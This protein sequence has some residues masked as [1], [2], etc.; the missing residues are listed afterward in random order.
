MAS[1][2]TSLS[3]AS[4]KPYPSATSDDNEYVCPF[5][6]YPAPMD[7]EDL[8]AYA[9]GSL[10][11]VHLGDIFKSSSSSYQILLKIGHGSYSTVWLARD[12][13][14]DDRHVALKF[15][16]AG[17]HGDSEVE[18]HRWIR[19]HKHDHPGHQ[20]TLQMLD[21][22]KVGDPYPT[23]NVVVTDV[24][25]PIRQLDLRT[26]EKLL[27]SKQACSQPA[28]TR[29][30][31]SPQSRACTGPEQCSQGLKSRIGFQEQDRF[32]RMPKYLVSNGIFEDYVRN[33]INSDTLRSA[34]VKLQIIDFSNSYRG[35]PP[36]PLPA[37]FPR[38]QAPE[39]FASKLSPAVIKCG[40]I[41]SDI[42]SAA[43]TIF[44]IVCPGSVLFESYSRQKAMLEDVIERIGPLPD[45]WQLTTLDS[46]QSTS[47][48]LADQYWEKCLSRCKAFQQDIDT[49]RACFS[50]I[51]RMLQVNPDSR[52]SVELLCND[53][54]WEDRVGDQ[55]DTGITI[56]SNNVLA[57]VKD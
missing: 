30:C 12:L 56:Q 48:A 8:G 29:P 7:V 57:T 23:H 34:E 53:Q 15:L 6:Y 21:D 50:L 22:F 14:H 28:D 45:S 31:F 55:V 41:Q 40:G 51:R 25:I 54:W 16:T 43:C 44:E 1:T 49:A 13:D 35:L 33:V 3:A 24:L 52:P 47:C 5:F 2:L 17:S 26:R 39:I 9:D 4:A 32:K 36:S 27:S 10:F 38:V 46:T 42:W 11:P 19:E 37:T 20:Y 18:I